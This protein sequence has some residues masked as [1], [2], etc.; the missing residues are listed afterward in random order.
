MNKNENE[1]FADMLNESPDWTCSLEGKVVK[2][3][4]VGIDGDRVIVD[5]GLKAE[6]RLLASDVTAANGGEPVKID[7]TVDVY[8]EKFEDKNGE[9]V[10]SIERARK[11]AVW[12]DIE[13]HCETGETIEGIII[14]RTKRGFS[15]DINGALAFLPGSQVDLRLVKDITPLLNIPQPFKVLKTDRSRNNIVVSR[16]VVLEAT[17]SQER[18]EVMSRL[19]EGMIINGIVKNITEYGVFVDIGG[20]DGLL[21]VTDMSWKRVANPA[22]LVNVGDA[23]DVV[24][25]KFNK[26]SGRVSLGMKQLMKTPWE[27]IEQRYKIGERYTGRIVNITDYGAF[28]ELEECIEGM[29]YMTE[30]SWVRRS[31]HPNK[32]VEVGQ[33]VEVMVLDVIPSKRKI[34]L[35][36]KQC[37]PNPWEQF[38]QEHPVG[39]KITGEVK[40]IT[41]FGIF[42]GVTDTLDGMIHMSDVSWTGHSNATFE[43]GE[44]IEVV[45]LDVKPDKERINLG[46]KQLV[47]DPHSAA[48]SKVKKGDIVVTEIKAVHAAGV[49]VTLESGLRG[50]IKKIDISSDRLHQRTDMLSIGEKLEALVL[51]VERNGVVNL[52]VKSLEIQREKEALKKYGSTDSGASLGDIL[53]A[54]LKSEEGE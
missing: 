1:S 27:N 25:I 37:L 39:T 28:V 14:G 4:I 16:R 44:K 41:E 32:I 29:I 24:V 11:E 43:K 6:G 26:E 19:S 30:F 38:A 12:D 54:A 47:E 33:I 22:D 52:S 3:K 10:L 36:L 50:F 21:H 5:V 7:D 18:A 13:R 20:I 53:G 8:V 15:V 45:I 17:R 35:G 40:N 48:A 2:G 42:V 34:S 46:I 49:D 9:P 31:V 51:G 23:V